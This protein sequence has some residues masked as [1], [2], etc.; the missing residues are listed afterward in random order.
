MYNASAF[1]WHFNPPVYAC[2]SRTQLIYDPAYFGQYADP[3]DDFVWSITD[4]A[5]LS[6]AYE[7]GYLKENGTD[8]I[9]FSARW[10]ET[11]FEPLLPA[12]L[13]DVKLNCRYIGSSIKYLALWIS[14]VAITSFACCLTAADWK[15]LYSSTSTPLLDDQECFRSGKKSLKWEEICSRAV[16]YFDTVLAGKAG[17]VYSWHV[18]N[19]LAEMHPSRSGSLKSVAEFVRDVD[20]IAPAW[21]A[22]V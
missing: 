17:Q 4:Q 9:S 10:N 19:V 8:L 12:A 16:M 20:S 22:F 6:A 1:R 15:S 11:T 2:Y 3:R 21:L 14:V 7:G 18:F 5:T 13:D